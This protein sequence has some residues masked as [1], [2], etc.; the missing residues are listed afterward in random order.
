M[1]SSSKHILVIR[2]SAMGDVAMSIP[3]IK[4]MTRTYPNVKITVVSRVF[5]KPI[6]QNIPNVSFYTADVKSKHKGVSGLFKLY[7]ELKKL[8]VDVVADLH[9]VLRSKILGT[10]F[11]LGGYKVCTIDKGR[12]EKKALTQTKSKIFKQLKTTHERYADVFRALGYEL[13]L[14][15]E[16]VLPQLKLTKKVTSFI[17]KDSKK[18]IG[19]APFA[20]FAGKT[21]PT[22]QMEEVIAKLSKT[23]QYKIILFGG[24]SDKNELASW[25]DTYDDVYNCAGLFSFEE[26][27]ILISNLDLMLSMDS[28]NAHLAAMFGKKVVTIWGI[29]HPYAGFYP[30]GQPLKN[31]I[32]A[33]KEKYPLL[34][35]SIYGNKYPAGYENVM[36]SITPQVV[37]DKIVEV[38]KD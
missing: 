3:V 5:L 21:Y 7:K 26:E 6:F 31:A 24:A 16:D 10:F 19:I 9:N 23:N 32:F 4:A 30:F 25:H 38:L 37:F 13:K 2:L 11:K 34:P 35:T 18:W 36:E 1:D 12:T 17:G 8:N 27:L 14:V 20:A 22:T 28:G 33:D 29:T 15:K